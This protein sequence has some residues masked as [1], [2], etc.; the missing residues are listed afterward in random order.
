MPGEL[1][2]RL[3]QLVDAMADAD[4][5]GIRA[6]QRPLLFATGRQLTRNNSVDFLPPD[7]RRDFP[8]LVM[9][10]DDAAALGIQDDDLVDVRS[11]SGAVRAHAALS[12]SIR[13]GVVTMAH[14]WAEHNVA[15]LTSRFTDVDPLTGQPV[16]TGFPVSV[17]LIASQPTSVTGSD[18]RP[19][20]HRPNHRVSM[21]AT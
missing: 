5:V 9:S 17:S 16:M 18:V 19:P 20:P 2:G 21:E 15:R 10:V 11:V 13:T 6:E 8:T 1:V 14:G 4:E 12:S 3:E 7:R